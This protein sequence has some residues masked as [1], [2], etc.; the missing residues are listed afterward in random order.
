MH[1][2]RQIGKS[3]VF[4]FSLRKN[5]F[6]FGFN[7]INNKN[8]VVRRSC[9]RRRRSAAQPYTLCAQPPSCFCG[10]RWDK[11]TQAGAWSDTS[12]C[13]WVFDAALPAWISWDVLP[14]QH[15]TNKC[16]P[17]L[18]GWRGESTTTSWAELKAFLLVPRWFTFTTP[19]NSFSRLHTGKHCTIYKMV[20]DKPII[21]N[22][23]RFT[24]SYRMT[25][26]FYFNLN[27]F[28][29]IN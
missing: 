21:K 13:I 9:Y 3:L 28:N 29:Y 11:S 23:N 22:R 5:Q 8:G 7:K 24:Y 17:A 6:E 12:S 16:L 15:A 14:Q 1:L 20:C 19:L 18:S 4:N 2:D 26:I 10:G 25:I 27:F